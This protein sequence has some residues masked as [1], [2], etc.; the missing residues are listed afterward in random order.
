MRLQTEL[1][2]SGLQSA[3]NAMVTKIRVSSGTRYLLLE[4]RR[5]V[6]D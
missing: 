5:R 4:R 6:A 2:C 3:A 1:I